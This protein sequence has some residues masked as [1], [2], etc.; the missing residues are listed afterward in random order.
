MKADI[1]DLKGAVKDKIEL[2]K[3]V[4]GSKISLGAIY[5]KYMQ[6][7]ANI[8]IGTAMKKNRALTR[9]G[10]KKPWRQKGT[11]R[12]RAGTRRSPLWKGGA[13]TFGGQRK[14]YKFDIPKKMK[15]KAFVSALS[16]RF[17]KGEI[18]FIDSIDVPL[19]KTKDFINKISKIVDL[20]L[21]GKYIFIISD[22]ENNLR[23]FVKNVQNV[24]LMN[25]NRMKLLP[26]ISCDSIFIT[27]NAVEEINKMGERLKG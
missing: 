26:L 21:K 2:N 11:G 9:G 27:K 15:T 18:K 14:V 23:K 8:H 22:K 4:F 1:I 3:D 24:Q 7:N 5:T 16:D 19:N 12:A 6:E 17:K 10:G 25:A 20:K 13:R